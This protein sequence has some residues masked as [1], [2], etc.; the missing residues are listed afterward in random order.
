[1]QKVLQRFDLQ[2]WTRN[3][4]TFAVVVFMVRFGQGLLGGARMV[5]F[6]ETL[7]LDGDQVLWLEGIR[8]LP[9]LALIFLAALTMR[10]QLKRQAALAAALMGVGYALFA[11][12]GSYAALLAVVIVASFGFHLWTPLNSAI[13]MSLSSKENT[14]RVLGVLGSVG[15]LAAIAGMGG[16]ALISWLYE[17]MPLQYYYLV[18]GIVI[19]IGALFLLRLPKDLG[20][21]QA[22]PARI[23]LK[24]KYWLYYVL[25]FFSGA[26][27]L[28]LGS[29]VT[30][31]LVDRFGLKVWQVSTLMLVSSVLNLLIGPYRGSL[32]DRFGER[33]T[34]PVSYGILALCCLGYA[35]V[36]LFG[37]S[38]S[39]SLWI[40]IALWIVIK[41]A[42][43]LGQG[44]ATYVY[45]TAPAEELTP[46]LT[47]G[48]TFDHISS[49]SMPFLYSALLPVIQY[50]GIFFALAILILLSIP[51]ARALQVR[52]PV[53]AQPVASGA[54]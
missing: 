53:P 21:T 36:P 25:V 31:M 32:I 41:L 23:L 43:P 37:L 22:K 8:E 54:E 51:F 10:V 24:K 4:I 50:E 14:G 5:F 17:S 30:L 3:L 29:F 44:L 1:M 16:L 28:V 40:L 33:F 39:Q 49:V 11:F 52:A 35:A 46:T 20:T 34:T 18:G 42:Q 19:V 9:G 2:I 12:A 26:R 7:H 38:A 27:K 6:V 48:V 45:R 13:G 47:A 15:S